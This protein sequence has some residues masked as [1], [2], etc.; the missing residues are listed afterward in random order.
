ML[1]KVSYTNDII[2]FYDRFAPSLQPLELKAHSTS[3]KMNVYLKWVIY[4]QEM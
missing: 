4:V 2:Y 3:G 1:V